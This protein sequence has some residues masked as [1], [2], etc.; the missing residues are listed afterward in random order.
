LLH[1]RE[2]ANRMD[3][4]VV[5]VMA[6]KPRLL[7]RARG[8]VPRP[9]RLPSGF[10]QAPEI[11]AY[12]G[13]LKSAFCLVKD[14][15]AMLSQHQGDLEHPAVLDDYRKNLALFRNLFEHRPVALAADVH[16][17]Y[18]SSKIARARNAD[19]GLP[20]IQIQHHHAHIASCLVENGYALDDPPVLGIALDGL[21]WGDDETIWGGEFL[22]CDYRNVTRV[23]HF[24]PVAMPGGVQAIQQPWRNLYAHLQAAGCTRLA[25]NGTGS[26]PFAKL[27]AKPLAA[28]D[29][30]IASGFQSPAAS[31]CGRLFDAVA[32]ALNICF[33]EQLYEGE[34]ATR[35]ESLAASADG[36]AGAYHMAVR[37][38]D[39]S[40]PQL[41]PSCL[42]AEIAEDLVAGTAPCA[43]AARFHAGLVNGI[44]AM[45][46]VLAQHHDFQSIA[47]SG[48]C[49]QNR[50]LFESVSSSLANLDFRVFTHSQV[51]A[52][53][54]GL[55]LGQAAIAAAR[56]IDQKSV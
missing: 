23:G 11:L 37:C 39:D 1:D 9:I 14:G 40:P 30:L 46:E 2:I 51:P 41:D 42:W 13:E 38:C 4:S 10:E 18:L 47:L 22:L 29:S 44:M 33:D 54:G 53:D 48:G 26:A 6:G 17:E 20:L 28:L 27:V 21:G 7:R 55:A 15:E 56:L 34:A 5:R 8:Y 16:P 31:S 52:N 3:D 32:A 24:K 35:L 36:D 49:F 43:I 25:L 50:L 45:V 19:E 12:G